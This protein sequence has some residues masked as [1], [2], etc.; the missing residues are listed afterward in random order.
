MKTPDAV[1]FVGLIQGNM[2][3][4]DAVALSTVLG[5][6]KINLG[7]HGIFWFRMTKDKDASEDSIFKRSSKLV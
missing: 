3:F 2:V 5:Y 4:E 6:M 1:S 7:F